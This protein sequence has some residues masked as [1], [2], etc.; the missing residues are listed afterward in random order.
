MAAACLWTSVA[1]SDPCRGT[2]DGMATGPVTAGLLDGDLGRAHRACGRTEAGIS[3]GGLLIVDLPNFYG[4]ISGNLTVDGSWAIGERSELFATVELL[5]YES[6]ITP[7]SSS[8]LGF[9]HTALG[10]AR[11][12]LQ[13]SIWSLGVHGK[14]VLPTA[15]GIYKHSW[16]FGVDAALSVQVRPLDFLSAHAEL[17]GLFSA[18]ASRGASLPRA[19]GSATAGLELRPAR[20]FAL[21]VDLHA[22][23]AYADPANTP[24]DVFAAAL[25]LRFAD[26]RRFGFEIGATVPILGRERALANLDLRGS[27]RLGKTEPW[28][29]AP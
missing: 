20:S 9:G 16:P 14:I 23:V 1:H 27:V 24:L 3:G 18:A 26:G 21:A 17:G 6:L 28:R 12:V 4:R 19:G 10:A 7:M 25:A 2:T 8:S 15:F 13:G 5:R 22:V 29:K 11:R